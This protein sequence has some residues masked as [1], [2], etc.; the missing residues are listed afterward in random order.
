MVIKQEREKGNPKASWQTIISERASFSWL[1]FFWLKV[2]GGRRRFLHIN[3]THKSNIHTYKKVF[4]RDEW[5]RLV[6]FW[7]E[8]PQTG[9]LLS[10]S[11][12]CNQE[13]RVYCSPPPSSWTIE[14]AVCERDAIVSSSLLHVP[15]FFLCL[16]RMSLIKPDRAKTF[17]KCLLVLVVEGFSSFFFFRVLCV[18]II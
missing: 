8:T 4:H 14:M 1:F 3:K 10:V 11:S 15:P 5:T 9:F 12:E 16:R 17:E 6:R 2:E 13:V 18:F 7:Q